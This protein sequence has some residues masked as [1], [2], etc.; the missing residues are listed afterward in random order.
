MCHHVVSL[1]LFLRVSRRF[2]VYL[3]GHKLSLSK[4]QLKMNK[5]KA[6]QDKQV[7]QQSHFFAYT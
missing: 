4:Q 7:Q 2:N 3:L 1:P 6:R 5:R